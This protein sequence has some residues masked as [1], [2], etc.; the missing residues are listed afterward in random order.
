MDEVIDFDE[1]CKEKDTSRYVEIIHRR[2]QMRMI[3]RQQ[4]HNGVME[5]MEEDHKKRM[6]RISTIGGLAI[7]AS[8]SCFLA[9]AIFKPLYLF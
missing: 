1:K 2:A 3:N 8:L 4:E 5:Q 7:L 9:A 6:N